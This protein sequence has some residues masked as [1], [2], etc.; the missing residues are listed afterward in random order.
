MNK[1][2]LLAS[3]LL[4][5]TS[6]FGGK[7][8]PE[9]K[10][11]ITKKGVE[12]LTKKLPK[13]ISKSGSFKL[14]SLG[15]ST[16]FKTFV[17]I[18]DTKTIGD[19]YKN[20]ANDLDLFTYSKFVIEKDVH[21]DWK[22]HI[23][24][25]GGGNVNTL[26]ISDNEEELYGGNKIKEIKELAV[27]NVI[28]LYG[29]KGKELA[30]K[31]KI[32]SFRYSKYLS[33]YFAGYQAL[34]NA[35]SFEK[36]DGVYSYN[37]TPISVFVG[38]YNDSVNKRKQKAF[39]KGVLDASKNTEFKEFVDL[40]V[41]KEKDADND[42]TNNKLYKDIVDWTSTDTKDASLKRYLKSD[43]FNDGDKRLVYLAGSTAEDWDTKLFKSL[44][45]DS[46]KSNVSLVLDTSE[47]K[48]KKLN[49]LDKKLDI[50]GF[51]GNETK[52]KIEALK[53]YIKAQYEGFSTW[54]LGRDLL[55]GSS[56]FEFGKTL[57]TGTFNKKVL[58][59]LWSKEIVEKEV[60]V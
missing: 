28:Y 29:K 30:V 26:V 24:T 55:N 59:I 10:V 48:S 50:L 16:H 52:S 47:L 60:V 43:T 18:R 23:E 57:N 51:V 15:E 17:D 53:Y 39:L 27:D 36:E 6:C 40:K 25:L 12:K 31:D 58:D 38:A 3:L 35:I 4:V 11:D 1:K 46:K 21:S 49:D 20:L 45:W 14:G 44:G 41:V 56:L 19:N 33:T 9:N 13:T 22:E 32:T 7:V 8:E 34:V 42:K 5:N 37:K 54:F 2:A